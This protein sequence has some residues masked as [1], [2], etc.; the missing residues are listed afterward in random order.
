MTPKKSRLKVFEV[1]AALDNAKGNISA[2]ARSFGIA[3]QTLYT[4]IE[5]NPTLK[6]ALEDA[7]ESLLDSAESKLGEAIEKGEAWAVCFALKTIGKGRGYVEKQEVEH[8]G[9]V[10][11]VRIPAKLTQDEWAQQQQQPPTSD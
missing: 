8:S 5:K 7:R 6:A 11:I 2:A 9:G 4:F 10:S 3:R 1:A